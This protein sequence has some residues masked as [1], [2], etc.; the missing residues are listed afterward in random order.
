MTSISAEFVLLLVTINPFAA[1]PVFLSATAGMT[2]AE[3]RRTALR[4]CTI[5]SVILLFLLAFG[6]IF[7]EKIGV[8]L[9]ALR[10][11]G[12]LVLLILGL[13]MVFGEVPGGSGGSAPAGDVAVFPLAMP[14]L[15]GG[16][17]IAAIV[18]MTDHRVNSILDQA[19]TALVL[20]AVMAVIYLVLRSAE[21]IQNA[22]GET[23]TNVMSRIMGLVLAALA[24]QTFFSVFGPLL[25][26]AVYP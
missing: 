24:V 23:G 18:A 19:V 26:A 17:S 2:E 3:R 6:Q 7:L 15:A 21:K 5:A 14:M 12:A 11:A 1:L 20:I 4:A 16:G 25:G 10:I 8:S 9:P 22:I 13:R